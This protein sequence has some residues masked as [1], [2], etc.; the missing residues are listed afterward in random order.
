[1]PRYQLL[2]REISD[3]F[4][5]MEYHFLMKRKHLNILGRTQGLLHSHSCKDAGHPVHPIFISKLQMRWGGIQCIG[6][7]L[8]EKYKL[9]VVVCGN[10]A[11]LSFFVVVVYY[12]IV[13]SL[14][15]NTKLILLCE[16]LFKTGPITK[17][18]YL[19]SNCKICFWVWHFL[20]K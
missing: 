11:A 12:L 13:S 2:I 10:N 7:F 19:T 15:S 18:I 14:K 8:N 20:F 16:K 6:S 3:Y 1:M 5:V 17:L 9:I 4:C